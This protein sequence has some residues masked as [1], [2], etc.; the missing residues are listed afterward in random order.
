MPRLNDEL[1]DL[2]LDY[3]AIG[4][5]LPQRRGLRV[6]FSD[7]DVFAAVE[8]ALLGESIISFD[9]RFFNVNTCPREYWDEGFVR[10]LL[11]HRGEV[12]KGAT[13]DLGTHLVD[14]GFDSWEFVR[15]GVVRQMPDTPFFI[16]DKNANFYGLNLSF[17][18]PRI[19]NYPSAR[20]NVKGFLLVARGLTSFVE[21]ARGRASVSGEEVL[22]I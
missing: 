12:L 15:P 9:Q 7:V 13:L 16:G 10:F 11:D 19:L 18:D 22:K 1:D 21:P 2:F 6:K 8:K 4:K 17:V 5:L 14:R 20:V 3:S